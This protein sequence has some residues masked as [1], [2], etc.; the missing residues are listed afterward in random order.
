MNEVMEK[1]KKGTFGKALRLL[2]MPAVA[3]ISFIFLA[4][5]TVKAQIEASKT[6][7]CLMG[8][9]IVEL[10]AL[11]TEN[12]N[13]DYAWTLGNGRTAK[14]YRAVA[15][16]LTPGQYTVTLRIT[17]KLTG[18]LRGNWSQAITVHENPVVDFRADDT[19][20]CF[21]HKVNFTDA[22]VPANGTSFTYRYW[23]FGNGSDLA[24]ATTASVRYDLA[25]EY[26]PTLRIV[27]SNCPLDTFIVQKSSFHDRT[28]HRLHPAG[29]REDEEH[30][31]RGT[32][33][34]PELPVDL[35]GRQPL[36]IDGQGPHGVDRQSRR[37]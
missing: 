32:G 37:L 11:E 22:S 13:H 1:T 10:N 35:L 23:N 2:G 28:S 33:T 7:G 9:F 3:L 16:Y 17:D 30:E 25:A 8:G 19:D 27:Q 5:V 24:N 29:G 18:L 26:T 21:P 34:D 12:P 14:T 31:H 15:Q 36:L 6:S 20:G 4:P